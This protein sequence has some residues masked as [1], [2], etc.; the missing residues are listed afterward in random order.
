[1]SDQRASTR[2]VDQR[3]RTRIMDVIEIYA[4]GDAGVS[5]FGLF[6]NYFEWFYDWIPHRDDGAFPHLATLTDAENAALQMVSQIVDD[7][8]GA[9]P[10]E[11][12]P[13]AFIATAW[14][15]RIQPVARHALELMVARGWFSD[16]VEEDEPSHRSRPR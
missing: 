16:D 6:H 12:S 13:D 3:I 2:L 14:P 11:M 8:C 1:M 5:E 7:A 9:T 15:R 10:N 4:A